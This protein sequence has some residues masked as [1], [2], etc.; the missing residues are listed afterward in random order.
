MLPEGKVKPFVRFAIGLFILISILSPTLGYLYSDKDF[1]IDLWAH[2]QSPITEEEI[3]KSGAKINEQI[4]GQ[5]DEILKQ[6]LEGQ[7]SAVAMLVPGVQ[8]VETK[9]EI[10]GNGA[11]ANLHIV[12]RPEVIAAEDDTGK[13]GVFSSQP[14]KYTLE[15]REAIQEKLLSVVKNMYGLEGTQIQVEFEGG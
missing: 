13:I 14:G 15:E 7:I 8:E 5:G 2:T 1:Q 11:V 12:V 9:A 6:K 10:S 4:M 3:L